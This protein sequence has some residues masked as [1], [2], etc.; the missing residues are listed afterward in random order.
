LA[1]VF[2]Q[3]F[4]VGEADQAGAV[5][6][7]LGPAA[8]GRVELGLGDG[9]EPPAESP[10]V[11]PVGKLGPVGH[12]VGVAV[13]VGLQQAQVEGLDVLPVVQAHP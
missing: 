8:V 10:A 13:A 7:D 6:V 1:V 11:G 3:G 2:A 12:P 4:L 9:G 5:A